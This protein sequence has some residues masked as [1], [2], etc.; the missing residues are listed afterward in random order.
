MVSRHL[1]DLTLYDIDLPA[2][3]HLPDSSHSTV[4]GSGIKS[5]VPPHRDRR[6]G[7]PVT[8]GWRGGVRGGNINSYF[9]PGTKNIIDPPAGE[10]EAKLAQ[11]LGQLQPFIA[12]FPHECM[13]QLA[14]FG[15]T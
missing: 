5:E 13:G 6:F 1:P 15:P 4:I 14:S 3:L 8:M 10:K 2:G 11:K 7:T 12:V 9:P